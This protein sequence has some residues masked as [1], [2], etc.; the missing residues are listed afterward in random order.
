MSK[1]TYKEF[2]EG[3]TNISNVFEADLG[4]I[5]FVEDKM[6]GFT[7]FLSTDPGVISEG[8]TKEEA[9]LNL[10][11]AFLCIYRDNSENIKIKFK[12]IKL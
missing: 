7:S 2:E 6:G 12:K 4:K 10:L 9:F 3:K 8:D 11:E 1:I 5:T